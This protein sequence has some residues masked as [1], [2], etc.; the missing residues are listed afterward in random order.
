MGI[1]IYLVMLKVPYKFLTIAGIE[2][3]RRYCPRVHVCIVLKPPSN[4][5]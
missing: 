4:N 3:R 5:A 1:A 2:G